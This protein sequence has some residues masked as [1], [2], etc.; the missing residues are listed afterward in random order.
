MKT[1]LHHKTIHNYRTLKKNL[2]KK[3]QTI[4]SD[5]CSFGFNLKMS[6]AQ[7]KV[8]YLDVTLHIEHDVVQLEVPV[9]DSVQVEEH[10]RAADLGP[11]E[12]SNDLWQEGGDVLTYV[13]R[14]SLNLP[15]CWMWNMRSPP[16]TYS[17][18]KYRCDCAQLHYFRFFSLLTGK[19]KG[20]NLPWFESRS[21]AG[22]GR[23]AWDAW[24]GPSS[25]PSE[26]P[27][28]RPARWCLSSVSWWRRPHQFPS[29]PPAPPSQMIL[30]LDECCQWTV[31]N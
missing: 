23:E 24:P 19:K 22:R 21:E 31:G 27:G 8:C 9:N 20:K 28:H 4:S 29:A 14:G 15:D 10:D 30:G 12:S 13:A 5:W 16:G 6:L 7:T 2:K 3:D 11:I 17:N 1:N 26:T 25:P 18:T